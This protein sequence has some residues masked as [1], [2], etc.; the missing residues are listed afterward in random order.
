MN[1]Y[2]CNDS[3]GMGLSSGKL[4]QSQAGK[5]RR[6]TMS[7]GDPLLVETSTLAVRRVG[8]DKS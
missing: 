6:T 4:L 3:P 8:D 1:P 5:R 7:R 2:P